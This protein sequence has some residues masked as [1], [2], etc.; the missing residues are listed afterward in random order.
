MLLIYTEK[1]GKLVGSDRADKEVI[2]RRKGMRW[3][4]CKHRYRVEGKIGSSQDKS[5]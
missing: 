5:A 3:S 4:G 2:F 1:F